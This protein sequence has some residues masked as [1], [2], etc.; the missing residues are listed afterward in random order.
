MQEAST[1]H[2]VSLDALVLGQGSQNRWSHHSLVTWTFMETLCRFEWTL[3]NNEWTFDKHQGLLDACLLVLKEDMP[4][5][6]KKTTSL[7]VE[8][9]DMSSRWRKTYGCL[10]S[11]HVCLLLTWTHVFFFTQAH[12]FLFSKKTCKIGSAFSYYDHFVG[13]RCCFVRRFHCVS[14]MFGALSIFPRRS[15]ICV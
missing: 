9:D 15:L 4:S 3:L 8:Q 1:E 12:A 5:R 11:K 14:L 7:L 13:L 2:R 6:W 10:L